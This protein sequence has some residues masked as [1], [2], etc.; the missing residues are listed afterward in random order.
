M[1]IS[2]ESF[3]MVCFI[4][5][6]ENGDGLI[7]KHPSYITEK[8]FMLGAGFNAFAHLD[9]HNMRKVVAWHKFW[10]VALPAPVAAEYDLQEN[11]A[12]DLKAKGFEI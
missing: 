4:A 6:M 1:T 7:E 2:P 3:A 9:I 5:L 12:A 10:G 8:T 11:A